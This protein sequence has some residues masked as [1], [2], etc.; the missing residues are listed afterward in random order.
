MKNKLGVII[1][2]V[3]GVTGLL[4]TFKI[5]FLDNINPADEL[6]PGIVVILSIINGCIFAYLG[7]FIQRYFAK[8]VI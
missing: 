2:F 5:V 8:K 4:Y 7:S 6:A 3:I 1:G